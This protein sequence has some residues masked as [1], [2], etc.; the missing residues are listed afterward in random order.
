MG[1]EINLQLPISIKLAGD[2]LVVAADQFEGP[3]GHSLLDERVG[4]EVLKGHVDCLLWKRNERFRNT[5]S[6]N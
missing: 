4:A 3:V 1:W 5:P 6:V 2:E